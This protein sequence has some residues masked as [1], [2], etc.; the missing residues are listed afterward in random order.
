MNR[1]PLF[2]TLIHLK[3]NPRACVYTEPLWGIP[4]NLFMPYMSVYML[5]LGLNDAE[6]G[7]VATIS[8]LS[9][10]IF[11]ILGGVLTDKFGRRMTT[12]IFDIIAWGIPTFIWAISQN[13]YFFVVAAL[14][15]GVLR[16]TA[17]SW[18][19]LLVED[20]DKNELV[21]IYTWVYIAGLG[22]AFFAPF[23]G[24]L[25]KRFDM[26][27]TIRGLFFLAFVMMMFKFIL[28]YFITD[29]THQ[30]KVRL[31]ETRESGLG[32]LLRGYGVVIRNLF[33]AKETIYLL[34]IMIVMS[35]QGTV[36]NSFWSVI[37][38]E[39]LGVPI[40]F[41]GL[42]PFVKAMIMMWFFFVIVP[43]VH[44][45]H[46]KAPLMF[47]L[48]GVA[49]SQLLLIVIPEGWLAWVVI[50]VIIEAASLSMIQPLLDSLQVTLVEPKERARI[51]GV[52]FTVVLMFSAPFGWIGGL[53]SSMDRRFP[54]IMVIIFVII[55]LYMTILLPKH[56]TED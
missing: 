50:S 35:I 19:C 42:F 43:K 23:T 27:P 40:G 28:L 25:L 49:M 3:G 52:L 9:Q 47:G 29:E 34:V 20:A 53:L 51:I 17:N 13:F 39:S 7:I 16:V 48:I 31:E 11:S 10:M 18:N 4:Y 44:V 15:N 26:I 56:S 12:L 22:T 38:T 33:K 37:A 55:G 6:I 30:G 5:S 21:A 41:I 54:F 2:K 45:E 14:I 46:Y 24:L 1:N 36:S 8:L 32:E